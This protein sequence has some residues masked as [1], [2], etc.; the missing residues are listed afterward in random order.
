MSYKVIYQLADKSIFIA[1][2]VL[3]L[4]KIGHQFIY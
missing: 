4:V 3:K 2:N 1:I